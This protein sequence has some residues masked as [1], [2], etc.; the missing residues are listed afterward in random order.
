MGISKVCQRIRELFDEIRGKE[1]KS[2]ARNKG[3]LSGWTRE[4]SMPL[5]DILT[6]T[7]GK[8]GLSGVM[9]VRQYFEAAGK[10]EEA[11]SKQGYFKQRKKLNPEAFKVLNRHYLQGFYAGEEART[12]RGYLVMAVDGSRAEIPNSA[13]NRGTYGESENK[14]GKQ[15]ARANISALHEVFNRFIL[16]IGIHKYTD[17]E[18]AEAKAHIPELREIT[19]DRPTLLMFDRNY[20]SLEFIDFLERSGVKYLI[21]LHSN[22]FATERAG[23]ARADERVE[24]AHTPK[25]LRHIRQKFPLRASE[26]EGRP[27][28]PARII[29]TGLDNGESAAFVTNLTE[30]SAGDIKRLYKKRWSIEKKYHT[31]KN[32][33]KFESVTGKASVYVKQDFW[34]QMQVYNIVQDLITAAEKRAAGLARKKRFKYGMRINENIAIGLFKE[35][36][37]RLVVEGDELV[38]GAMFKRLIADM[39]RYIVPVRE[40]KSSPRKWKYFNKYKCNQKPSF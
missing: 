4:R 8:K 11:V 34:A 7:L 24:L 14:Y 38:K 31:L 37:V 3:D 9:E 28:T 32:K 23:M 40:L 17:S 39:G 36:F 26:L 1:I 25:R 20:S 22:D 35:R 6:C 30:G 16:D 5:H 10:M 19:G 13:E 15:V 27:S 29:K 18:I 21:R 12:W 2:A 33:L